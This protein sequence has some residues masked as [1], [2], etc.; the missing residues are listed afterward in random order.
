MTTKPNP[1]KSLS[2][3][4]ILFLLAALCPAIPP[5]RATEELPPDLPV[6]GTVTLIDLGAT[7]CIPCKMMAPILAELEQEYSGRAAVIFIDVWQHRD[8]AKKFAITSI[9]TQILYD[10]TG[11]EVWRHSG[12]LDKP[13]L[14]KRIDDLLL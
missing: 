6:P 9:P 14:K 7:S 13:F 8:M 10:K 1:T 5:V 4:I 12:F 3:A 2:V 11:K